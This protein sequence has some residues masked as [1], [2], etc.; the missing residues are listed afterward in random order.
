MNLMNGNNLLPIRIL[1]EEDIA[2]IDKILVMIAA[3]LETDL[4]H[5]LIHTCG[6]LL[7][8]V[9]FLQKELR[10]KETCVYA[11]EC[12]LHAEGKI[13]YDPDEIRNED[14]SIREETEEKEEG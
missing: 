3:R 5:V 4:E 9:E 7:D 12:M 11:L 14:D 2:E 8:Q 13:P 6:R 10:N 1:T